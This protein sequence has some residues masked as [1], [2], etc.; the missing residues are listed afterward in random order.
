[1]MLPDFSK[2]FATQSTKS[3]QPSPA[4]PASP[5]PPNAMHGAV[6]RERVMPKEE[7]TVKQIDIRYIL[8][9]LL[10]TF[11]I[12]GVGGVFGLN[13]YLDREIS[14]VKGGIDALGEAIKINDIYDLVTFD[15]QIGTLQ[16]LTISRG[17]Y[18]LLLSEVS[19]LV[20]PGVHYS[21]VSIVT[22]DEGYAVVVKGIAGSLAQ[23]HQQIQ[24]IEAAEGL[25]ADGSFDGYSLQ[26]S[27]SGSTTVLFTVSFRIVSEAV[28]ETLNNVS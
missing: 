13:V 8:G 19:R 22:N 26:H 23:Y 7:R 18:S 2:N 28:G 11:S 27:E 1:M 20:I 24:R 21:S 12:I 3:A 4:S 17:G 14:V 10:L 6:Q 16:D 9:V 15:R 5:S 25:L